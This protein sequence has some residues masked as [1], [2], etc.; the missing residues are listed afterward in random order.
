MGQEPPGSIP[1]QFAPEIFGNEFHANL[2]FSPDGS[3]VYWS[4]MEGSQI[5]FMERRADGWTLPHTVPFA[6]PAGTG[7]PMLA[8]DGETLFFVSSEPIEGDDGENIW[9]VT[10]TA[11]GWSEPEPIGSG[12]NSHSLHWTPSVSRDGTLYFSAG[13]IYRSRLNDGVYE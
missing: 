2:V 7:E 11:N 13:D 12:V 8:P 6:L 10:R 3:S 4:E 9:R 5:Q 1:V